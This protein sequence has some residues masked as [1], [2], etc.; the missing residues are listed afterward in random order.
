MSEQRCQQCQRRRIAPS[1]QYARQILEVIRQQTRIIADGA[2][3][4]VT[5][6][7]VMVCAGSTGCSSL[8]GCDRS[9]GANPVIEYKQGETVGGYYMSSPWTGPLLEFPGAK[10]YR[11][12]HELGQVPRNINCWVSFHPTG[13]EGGSIAE[14]AGNMC[15]IQEIT[16]EYIQI[17]NDTCSEM[18][19]LVTASVPL[20]VGEGAGGE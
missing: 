7:V 8:G 5:A 3:W 19:V 12:F 6:A 1:G 9:D 17:K 18:Y 13:I 20:E 10:R 14:A 16:R 15:V 11:L 4:A 2:R